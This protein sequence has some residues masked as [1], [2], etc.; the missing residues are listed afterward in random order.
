MG[1]FGL[2]LPLGLEQEVHLGLLLYWFS[3]INF[4]QIIIDSHLYV[5]DFTL[6]ATVV[7]G[8]LRSYVILSME[9]LIT[10][11]FCHT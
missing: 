2:K 9:Y 3:A 1:Q 8:S 6:G 10:I 4:L 5:V 11:F 7:H